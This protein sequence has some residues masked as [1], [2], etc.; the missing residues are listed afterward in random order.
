[1]WHFSGL[2]NARSFR[3]R[4]AWSSAVKRQETRSGR[5][6]RSWTRQRQRRQA[7]APARSSWPGPGRGRLRCGRC[8]AP[9]TCWRPA[10]LGIASVRT[11]TSA[12]SCASATAPARPRRPTCPASGPRWTG[13]TLATWRSARHAGVSSKRLGYHDGAAGAHL[14]AWR[15]GRLAFGVLYGKWQGLPPWI[16]ARCGA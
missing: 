16:R 8:R 2:C 6:R 14:A 11:A 12:P 15:Q 3:S 7:R 9:R 5:W 10:W 1:M 4:E 13:R